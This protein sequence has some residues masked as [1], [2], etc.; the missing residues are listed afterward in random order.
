MHSADYLIDGRSRYSM[1]PL[2]FQINRNKGR[3]AIR[4]LIRGINTLAA[5][6]SPYG[7]CAEWNCCPMQRCCSSG[8]IDTG[9]NVVR[10]ELRL[11]LI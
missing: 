9:C 5:H 8:L 11:L 10:P 6:M 3:T 4:T 7:D 1:H 2:T